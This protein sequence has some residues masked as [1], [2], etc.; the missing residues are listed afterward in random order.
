MSAEIP[1]SVSKDWLKLKA[2][3]GPR[4]DERGDELLSTAQSAELAWLQWGRARMSAE[5][6]QTIGHGS[7]DN[8]ASMGPRS[9]E[10][11]DSTEF[12]KAV[13]Y[14]YASMGPRSDERGDVRRS[15]EISGTPTALNVTDGLQWGRARMSAE[16]RFGHSQACRQPWRF[17]GAALG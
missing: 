12:R 7:W 3:M 8:I 10:R 2:S 14:L 9:D 13:K 5:M 17:N 1:K 16:M 15:A 4:S 6:R 11:G